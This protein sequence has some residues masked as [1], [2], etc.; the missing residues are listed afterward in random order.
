MKKIFVLALVLCLSFSGTASAFDITGIGPDTSFLDSLNRDV[1]DDIAYLRSL[2]NSYSDRFVVKEVQ[3]ADIS[4]IDEYYQALSVPLSLSEV[5]SGKLNIASDKAFEER[6]KRELNLFKMFGGLSGYSVRFEPVAYFNI[7]RN[8]TLV[9]GYANY[10]AVHS[11]PEDAYWQYIC[12]VE[13]M[14]KEIV[15]YD[16]RLVLLEKIK[17]LHSNIKQ[18]NRFKIFLLVDGKV[19]SIWERSDSE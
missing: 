12:S 7:Y 1:T 5:D 15:P 9:G 4:S 14:T 19:N 13:D 8:I 3:Y 2:A 6:M 17:T 10:T 18:D 16:T 11:N